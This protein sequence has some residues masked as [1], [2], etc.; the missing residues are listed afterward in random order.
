VFLD[1]DGVVNAALV[2]DGRPYPP[3]TVAEVE[4][5]PGVARAVERFS[6]A[7][8]TTV[9]V[10]NQPDIARGTVSSSLVDSINEHIRE[11]TGIEHFIVCPHDDADGCACR[12]PRPGMI[13]ESAR[14]LSIDLSRS[15]MV[16]DRWRDVEAGTSAGVPVVWI[17]RGYDE[18]ARLGATL[19]VRELDDAVDWIL[20]RTKGAGT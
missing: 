7:G 17:D 12:K 16:G 19:V 2:R 10:T 8:L 18:C 11:C 5:L 14:R 13:I 4:V 6:A 3:V 9:V 20:R 1:R 15:V